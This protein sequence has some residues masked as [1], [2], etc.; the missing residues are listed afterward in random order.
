MTETATDA[1]IQ[2]AIFLSRI[3]IIIP[4]TILV[5]EYLLT[6]KRE[7]RQFWGRPL[8]WGSFFFYLNRYTSIFGTIP[9]VVQ[10]NSTTTDSAKMP[11]STLCRAMRAY[12]Q[13]F[14]LVS[15]VM[16]AIILIMRTF[17]LYDRSKRILALTV[18]IT[19]GIFAF[20]IAELL[21]K[22]EVETLADNIAA[23]GCPIG[24]PHAKSLRLAAAWSG[25]LLF[26]VMIFGLTLYKALRLKV[27]RG[28]LLTILIR[29]GSVYF[30]LMIASNACNIGTYTMGGPFMSGTL[31][32][33]TNVL[34]SVMISRLMFNLSGPRERLPQTYPRTARSTTDPDGP[35]ISTINPYTT[36]EYALDTRW[37]E[38]TSYQ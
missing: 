29:D 18:L 14:A 35:A 26:D 7:T 28:E 10:Y 8:T 37:T 21:T 11:V 30:A 25:M 19:L 20:A 38:D 33:V 27:G 22:T 17:A 12:H 16:V 31:T 15:Q 24:T 13:Y 2:Q 9:V 36:T 32:T 34:A 23:F 5:Y 3:L 1:Q 4:F 6:L